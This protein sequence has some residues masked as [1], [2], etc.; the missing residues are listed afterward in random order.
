MD[1]FENVFLSL[2]SDK[3]LVWLRY[4]DDVL[5]IW[6]RGEKELHKFT[7]NLS[8]H[9]PNINFTYT[10]VKNVSLFLIWMSIYQGVSLPQI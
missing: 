6:T 8:N 9:Q 4:I 1:E 5:F 3:P 7:D 10:S 2:R